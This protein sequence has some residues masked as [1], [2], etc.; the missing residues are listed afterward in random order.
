MLISLYVVALSTSPRHIF[1]L[2]TRKLASVIRR[3]DF[4]HTLCNRIVFYN[5]IQKYFVIIGFL[6]D[7]F[8]GYPSK[9]LKTKSS[10]SMKYN[11]KFNTRNASILFLGYANNLRELSLYAKILLNSW[12]CMKLVAKLLC[13]ANIICKSMDNIHIDTYLT[14]KPNHL[15]QW[16]H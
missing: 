7:L 3:S 8:I 11:N 10:A 2:R 16:N 6:L 9:S 15:A 12:R 5:I 1:R 14:V 13:T 4:L